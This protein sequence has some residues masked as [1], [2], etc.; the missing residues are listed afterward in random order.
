[1]MNFKSDNIVGVHPKIMAAILQANSGTEG[2]YGNDSYSLALKE[3]F[4]EIFETEVAIYLTSTGTAAN[5][6]ALSALVPP[7]GGIYCHEHAH[8]NTDE[9]GAPELFTGGAKLISVPGE[10]GKLDV[11]Y[12]RNH[13][14]AANSLRPHISKPACISISQATEYGTIY[15]PDELKEIAELAK[16]Y[17]LNLHMDGARFANSLV[18]L[19]V[20]P[21]TWK[22]GVDAMSFG[23]T[24]NGAMAAEAIIFFNPQDAI[25]FDYYHKR[26][27]QMMSK[28]RFFA[29]QLLAY[30]EDDL[31]LQN[32]T[33]ANSMAVALREIFAKHNIEIAYPVEANEVF[34]RLSPK[35]SEYLYKN[36][37][38]FYEWGT[39]GCGL[40][41]FV[42]SCFTD[43]K[44]LQLLDNCIKQCN[45]I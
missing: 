22:S 11:D 2:S 9:A 37:G 6:L 18:T 16:F 36:G 41:R 3:K 5:S 14:E 40:Y 17:N 31:W 21:A 45:V 29:C 26:G 20:S 32:A 35:I 25:E 27:G 10:N 34:V 15:Q 39:P 24:K 43:Q 33:H 4:C 38:G 28:M 1:M 12:I 8:I 13:I 44:D 30:L 19:G 42:T 23:A 7:Y